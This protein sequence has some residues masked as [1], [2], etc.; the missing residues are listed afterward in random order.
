MTIDVV[1]SV[2]LYSEKLSGCCWELA[3][4]SLTALRLASS[5]PFGMMAF[6]E[7]LVGIPWRGESEQVLL[8]SPAL[9]QNALLGLSA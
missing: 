8:D 4:P 5:K 7:G 6:K 9:V 1:A 2:I 3:R